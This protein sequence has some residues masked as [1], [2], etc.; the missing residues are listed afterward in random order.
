MVFL[1]EIALAYRRNEI[2]EDFFFWLI[3]KNRW[4]V[5]TQKLCSCMWGGGEVWL[6]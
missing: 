2:R 4:N 1:K 5:D 6:E 3:L